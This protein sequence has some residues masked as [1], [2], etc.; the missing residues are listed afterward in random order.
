[1]TVFCYVFF[2]SSQTYFALLREYLAHEIHRKY[3]TEK[4]VEN[5]EAVSYSSIM[6]FFCEQES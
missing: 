6:L 4:K 5:L 2:F 3:I 1:M